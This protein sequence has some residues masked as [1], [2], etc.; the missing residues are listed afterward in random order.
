MSLLNIFKKNKKT[1]KVKKTEK[2]EKKEI[3]AETPQVSSKPKKEAGGSAYKVLRTPH[4]TEK[5]TALTEKNFYVFN[6]FEKSNKIEIK[7]AVEDLY[8]VEVE[9]V[10]TINVLPK[11]RRI[12]KTMGWSK[13]Y[14]KAIVKIK[15]GQKIEVL[16]R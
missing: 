14:K 6:V 8:G 10:K 2:K 7:R 16:P 9:S 4:I 1:E 3:K 13:G 15:A 5:A 12:G 11:K